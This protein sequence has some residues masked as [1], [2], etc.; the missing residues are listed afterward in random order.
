[1]RRAL[2]QNIWPIAF[3]ALL[4]WASWPRLWEFVWGVE[5]TAA[6]RG[7]RVA[8]KSGCFTCHGP[9]GIGGVPNPGSDEGEV[10]GFSGGTPMMYANS[11]EELR[12]YILD[13]A[14][15]RKRNDP[16]YRE[17][18][19][20]WLL[21]MPA[22]RDVLSAREV[23][24]LLAFI[25]AASA[26]LVPEDPEAAKGQ[27]LALRY[28]CF[29]CHGPMGSRGPANPGSFKGYIPGW[30]GNDFRELVRDD[31]ELR[32]WIE[33]GNIDRLREHWLARRYV[34]GQKVYMP[35]YKG[36]LSDEEIRALMAYVR[37]VNR[38]EWQSRPLPLGH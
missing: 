11:E 20:N 37:W 25:R 26:L 21:V 7:R 2:R 6:E 5:V 17:K 4:V 31:R 23:D 32:Q 33:E 19:R 27:E 22:Y 35:A 24:D 8:E 29:H 13:G 10:P 15:A 9:Q 3:F 34:E 36:V 28:G 12:E 30:W 14:P 38:G 1:V 18:I 16:A